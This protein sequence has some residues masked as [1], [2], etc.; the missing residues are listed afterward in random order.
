MFNEEGSDP[1]T[2]EL[3][4]CKFKTA[5]LENS[6]SWYFISKFRDIQNNLEIFFRCI[7]DH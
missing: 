2:A 5:F 4:S 6:N 1:R 7:T 3:L